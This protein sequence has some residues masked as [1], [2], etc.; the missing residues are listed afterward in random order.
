[1]VTQVTLLVVLDDTVN[2]NARSELEELIALANRPGNGVCIEQR[3]KSS[4]L[5]LGDIEVFMA[6]Q[7]P[8]GTPEKRVREVAR[9]FY[10]KLPHW[11]DQLQLRLICPLCYAERGA[12]RCLR[13]GWSDYGRGGY[14][15]KM[16]YLVA[17][18]FDPQSVRR[19]TDLQIAGVHTA[20]GQKLAAL[21]SYLSAQSS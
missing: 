15:D 19:L 9:Q 1:M 20:T 6:T 16:C 2:P 21:R 11:S 12:C 14:N 8:A 18:L 5:G 10:S 4:L 17:W 13:M 7:L 3:E